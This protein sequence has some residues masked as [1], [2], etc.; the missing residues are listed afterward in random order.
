MNS[1]SCSN[2]RPLMCHPAGA[3]GRRWESLGFRRSVR[4]GAGFHM[5]GGPG[6]LWL[7]CVEFLFTMCG[8][9]WLRCSDALV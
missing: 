4:V 8:N 9:S 6:Q 2:D 3:A 5:Y 7:V 1:S